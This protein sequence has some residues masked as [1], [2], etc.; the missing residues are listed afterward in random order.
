MSI[1]SVAPLKCLGCC[2]LL[3]LE[4]QGFQLFEPKRKH[5]WRYFNTFLHPNFFVHQPT[6]HRYRVIEH[7]TY[8][9]NANQTLY[10]LER[11]I[12]STFAYW[13]PVAIKFSNHT[14]HADIANNIIYYNN[15]LKLTQYSLIWNKI[16]QTTVF[17]MDFNC[18]L[19]RNSC[20][21]D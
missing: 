18:N 21:I 9:S 6:I 11:N 16:N 12:Y 13:L 14:T 19:A 3:S 10:D 8:T 17:S 7:I 2:M 5:V 15:I 1:W 20:Q 4:W